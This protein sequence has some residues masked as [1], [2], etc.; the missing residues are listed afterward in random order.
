MWWDGPMDGVSDCSPRL[1]ELINYAGGSV[2]SIGNA[3]LNPW[4]NAQI[5]VRSLFTIVG[6]ST[7]A[8]SYQ[9]ITTDAPHR[10]QPGGSLTIKN[11]Q[12]SAWNGNW[13]AEAGTGGS[14]IYFK[15][16]VQLPPMTTLGQV[17]VALPPS[18]SIWPARDCIIEFPAGTFSLKSPLPKLPQI[19]LRGQSK[20][21]TIFVKRF[22]GGIF[23]QQD[24]TLG[25]GLIIERMSVLTDP[26][27]R[28]GYFCYL[29]GLPGSP[30]QPDNFQLK[31][32]YISQYGGITGD[33]PPGGGLWQH[34]IIVDGITRTHPQ[35]VRIGLVE[36]C[37]IF[38]CQYTGVW[39]RNGVGIT[40]RGGG[41]FPGAAGAQFPQGT[42]VY[43]TG[44]PAVNITAANW[45]GGVVSFTT[46]D[47]H[48]ILVGDTFE[49]KGATPSG[50]NTFYVATSIAG[51][52]NVVSA[53]QASFPGPM[54]VLG[55]LSN[56]LMQS[57][58]NHFQGV[59]NNCV[60]NL[61][62]C[63]GGS[64]IGGSIGGLATDDSS[65]WLIRTWNSGS[66][67][68]N[69]LNSDVTFV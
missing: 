52:P 11:C 48:T 64:W 29:R 1:T 8:T 21:S 35:G 5:P 23:F 7:S 10:L 25:N 18:N 59:I 37:E 40:M 61:S 69:L 19:V 36:N 28:P 56:P 45:T 51:G 22:H 44:T 26:L 27:Y 32:L 67:S 55:R 9:S 68:N 60:L 30:Y 17:T 4:S 15:S 6:F 53:A 31:D 38:N 13:T 66:I 16:A 3:T 63:M 49:V 43:I 41:L 34:G 2:I 20:L 54:T 14:V 12:P 50:F 57:N 24:G 58:N 42:G 33:S 46:A 62:A 47:P 65:H 39:I